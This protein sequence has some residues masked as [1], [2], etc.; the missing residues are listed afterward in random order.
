[1]KWNLYLVGTVKPNVIGFPKEI[2]IKK[3]ETSQG[4]M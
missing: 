2:I 4:Y 1:L 3:L